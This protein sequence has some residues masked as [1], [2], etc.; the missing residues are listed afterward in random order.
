MIR[1]AYLLLLLFLGSV[2]LSGCSGDSSGLQPDDLARTNESDIRSRNYERLRSDTAYYVREDQE[3]QVNL[4]INNPVEKFT[5]TDHGFCSSDE[6]QPTVNDLK[7]SY[8]PIDTL[9]FSQLIIKRLDSFCYPKRAYVRPYLEINGSFIQY[10]KSHELSFGFKKPQAEILTLNYDRN[11]KEIRIQ[12]A[13]RNVGKAYPVKA[14]GIC[15]AQSPSPTL[16]DQSKVFGGQIVEPTTFKGLDGYKA[17]DGGNFA[18]T[19]T[20]YFRLYYETDCGIQY[21]KNVEQLIDEL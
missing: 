19:G 7:N 3:L 17:L 2:L 9:V 11:V 15:W 6:P 21:G 1:T 16:E 4:L 18:N 14:Y 5:I 13:I 20:Y 12:G 8:G 10:G